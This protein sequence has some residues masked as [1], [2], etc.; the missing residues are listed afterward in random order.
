MDP[1]DLLSKILVIG[2]ALYLGRRAGVVWQRELENDRHFQADPGEARRI[3]ATC[4]DEES[5]FLGCLL[6]GAVGDALGRMTESLPRRLVRWRYGTVRDYRQGLFR[7]VRGRGHYTDDTQ[8]TLCVA[9]SIDE[10][11]N[12]QSDR[13][14]R[15]LVEWLDYRIGAGRATVE[16]AHRLRK[17]VPWGQAGDTGSAGNGSAIRVS[18]IGLIYHRDREKLLAAAAD[19]SVGTHAHP[20]TIA[21]A[22]IVAL[23]VALALDDRPSLFSGQAF[24]QRLQPA[25]DSSTWQKRLEE[26]VPLLELPVEAALKQIGTGGFVLESVA[27]ALYLFAREGL[28]LEKAIVTAVNAGGD[29]DSVAS[30]LGNLCGALHGH[31]AVPERW[32]A[33]LQHRDYIIM[34]AHR[35]YSVAGLKRLEE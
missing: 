12:F 29:T 27:A 21:A 3:L 10:V 19:S 13:L 26:L 31:Q 23:G 5:R 28:N 17:G 24:L 15:E 18:P 9:R 33:E 8:L 35:L 16:S 6:A 14:Q 32:L 22:R 2:G 11:G 7:P 1:V 30:I 34:Q 20:L 4:S 25:T